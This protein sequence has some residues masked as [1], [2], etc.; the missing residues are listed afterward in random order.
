MSGIRVPPSAVHPPRRARARPPSKPAQS[1]PSNLATDRTGKRS[2]GTDP[3]FG[4]NRGGNE[5]GAKSRLRMALAVRS[6]PLGNLLLC[7]E[8]SMKTRHTGPLGPPSTEPKV[9][10]SNPLGRASETAL[11]SQILRRA[12]AARHRQVG[13]GGNKTARLQDWLA[14][15]RRPGRRSCGRRFPALWLYHREFGL[16]IENSGL[17]GHAVGHNRTIGRAAFRV[18]PG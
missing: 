5:V 3:V 8:F 10:G 15:T 7:R 2:R 18:S 9:R 1:G 12:T 16:A 17:V 4:G 14:V 11:E 6:C 13:T